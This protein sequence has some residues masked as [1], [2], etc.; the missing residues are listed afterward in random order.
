MTSHPGVHEDRARRWPAPLRMIVS[1]VLA[2][3]LAAVVLPPLASPPPASL[4]A[5][6]LIQPLRPYIGLLYL[7]HGYRFFAP[8]PGPGHSLRWSLVTDGGELLEGSIPDAEK[9]WPRLL[10]HRRFMIPEKLSGMIPPAEAPEQIRRVARQEWGP[11]VEAVAAELL[12]RH[13]GVTVS[14]DM[15][16]HYLPTPGDVIDRRTKRP[17]APD[18]WIDRVTPLGTYA[19]KNAVYGNATPTAAAEFIGETR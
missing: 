13:Q 7:W 14:L 17:A 10:Y 1:F 11:L 12:T 19:L 4:L 5:N 18:A 9:D 15:V 16:E 2:V 8:D 6:R 3:H